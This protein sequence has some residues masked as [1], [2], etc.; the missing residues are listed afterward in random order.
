MLYTS[1]RLVPLSDDERKVIAQAL[2]AYRKSGAIPCTA[3][4]YCSPCPAGVDIP[5]N[6]GL[7]NQTKGGLPL[8][9][10]KLVYDAMQEDSRASSC[11]GCGACKRKCPQSIDIPRHMKEIA[12]AFK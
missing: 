1:F 9:H 11:V 5:R 4:R 12:K 2:A 6:L 7:L 10:A 3:C 8:F